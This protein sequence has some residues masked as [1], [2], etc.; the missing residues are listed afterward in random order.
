[1]TFTKI[2]IAGSSG[3]LA[4]HAIPAIVNSTKPKF[5]VTILTRVKSEEIA[6]IPG[7]KVIPVDYADQAVL[8]RAITG[9]DAI[10]SLVS[11]KANTQVDQALLAAART[12]GVRRIFQSEYTF[13]VLHPKAISLFTEGPWPANF[14]PLVPNARK[15][16]ALTEENGP[17]SFTTLIP[18]A[19]LDS[20]LCGDFGTFDPK[21]H[22]VTLHDGGDNPFTGCSTSFIA[23]CIVAALAMDEEKTKNKRIPISE[24]RTTMNEVVRA[25]EDVTGKEFKKTYTTTAA[26]IEKRDGALKGGQIGPAAFLSILAGAFDGSG[27]GDLPDGLEFDGD[28]HLTTKRRTVKELVIDAVKKATP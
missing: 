28:G 2:V 27:A 21:N 19:F 6:P 22:Q 1:M 20:W 8:V 9:A 13:D 10:V 5:D 7:A 26:I 3:R 12:A 4:D 17:T 18:A 23:S 14:T 25:F 24:V 11:G 15:F 16:C